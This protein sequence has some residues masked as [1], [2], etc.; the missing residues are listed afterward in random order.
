MALA[1]AHRGGAA[2]WPENT[3]LAFREALALGCPYLET[4]LHATRD[5]VL[6]CHHDATVDRTTDGHGAIREMTFAELQRL[7]AGHR[8]TTDGR[9]FPYRG[10]GLRVPALRDVVAL[11]GTAR[12]NVEV[13]QR[14]PDAC[15]PFWRFIEGNGLA[16]RFLVAA[17]EHALVR[18]FRALSGGA[19]AT[20]AS[21]PEV[22]AFVAAVNARVTRLLPV[23]YDALQVPVR[24]GAV[25]IVTPRLLRAAHARGVQVH[26]WTIDD[27]AEM[28]HLLDLG[29]D[30]L[31]SDRPD[32]LMRAVAP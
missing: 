25:G 15:E 27:G 1:F 2:L 32:V 18:R 7:D 30:G 14:A 16:D 17:S 28:Q 10:A 26:V 3:L 11:S 8:F 13:K 23:A 29:V 31:M 19:V 4:D 20:S 5:G 12:L 22:I 9:T 24:S 6:V 21:R